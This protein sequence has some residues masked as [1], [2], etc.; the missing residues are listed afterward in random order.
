MAPVIHIT[1]GVF[2][3]G[4]TDENRQDFEEAVRKTR[5]R[6]ESL[7]ARLGHRWPEFDFVQHWDD[8]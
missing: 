4:V 1:V 6:V 8:E 5:Q 3:A 2:E 7:V